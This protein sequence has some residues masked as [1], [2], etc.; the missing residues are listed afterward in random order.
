M[1]SWQNIDTVL[2]DMDG[3]LLDLHYDNTL[4]NQLLP[5][6]LSEVRNQPLHQAAADLT[7]HMAQTRNGIDFYCLDYWSRFTGLDIPALHLELTQM[8]RYRPG[9]QAFLTRLGEAGIR[10]ILVT[11]A[12]RG[13]LRVKDEHSNISAYLDL[14]ISCHDFGAPKESD[15]FWSAFAAAHPFDP[16]R[17]L[18]IDDTAT[19]L[20]AAARF[21]IAHLLMVDQ[22]DSARPTRLSLPYPALADFAAIM[23]DSL[24]P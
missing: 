16:Q 8:I 3:T 17:T 19:V 15:A 23:P 24:H 2:L 5:Q 21:G 4:W 13:S 22:P 6:R 20:D 11:N 1:I 10:R 7:D 9:A 12:H 18:F 14:C